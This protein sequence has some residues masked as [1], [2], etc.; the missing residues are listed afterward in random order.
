ML[1]MARTPKAIDIEDV[2][3]LVRIVEEVNYA[4]EPTILR[5][6]GEEMALIAPIT[7]VAKRLSERPRTIVEHDALRRSAGGWEGLVDV[8]DFREGN[9]ESRRL[10]S[11]PPVY[12]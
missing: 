7:A 1:P 5:R 4:N 10:S 3:E 12:L 11:R 6:H 8:E 9:S 2:P